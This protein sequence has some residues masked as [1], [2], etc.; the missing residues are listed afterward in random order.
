[1]QMEQEEIFIERKSIDPDKID[2]KSDDVLIK[3]VE[4]MARGILFSDEID[5]MDV[6][7]QLLTDHA[8]FYQLLQVFTS[9]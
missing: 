6:D 5:N 4:K 8:Q 7:I 2:R 3:D 1:M 9:A